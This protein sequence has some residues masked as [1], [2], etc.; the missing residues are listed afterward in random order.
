[1]LFRASNSSRLAVAMRYWLAQANLLLVPFTD[2][3]VHGTKQPYRPWPDISRCDEAG[4]PVDENG[5]RGERL[6]G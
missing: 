2:P 5:S 1:M 4:D 6:P 3:A